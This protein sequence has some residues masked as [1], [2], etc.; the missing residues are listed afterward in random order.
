MSGLEPVEAAPVTHDAK[1]A[2]K[3]AARFRVYAR[4]E[5][6]VIERTVSGEVRTALVDGTLIGTYLE[7][8]M[9]SSTGSI[10]L[11]ERSSKRKKQSDLN[12]CISLEVRTTT[13]K[14]V[15]REQESLLA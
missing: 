9:Q 15:V 2:A 1:P 6:G 14:L 10:I 12:H 7:L 5:R 13:D 4:R 8:S 11:W 3:H